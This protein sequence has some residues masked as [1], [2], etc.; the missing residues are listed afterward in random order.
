MCGLPE[1]VLGDVFSR[2]NDRTLSTVDT[3]Y[4]I[5]NFIGLVQTTQKRADGQQLKTG[6]KYA[7]DD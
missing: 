7:R 1:I 4:S 3:P 5:I 2:E 6:T